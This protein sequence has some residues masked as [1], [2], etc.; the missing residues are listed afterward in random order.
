[1][2]IQIFKNVKREGKNDPDYTGKISDETGK[3]LHLVS[4]WE[5]N[6]KAG[7]KYLNGYVNEPRQT[8][9]ENNGN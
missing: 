5:N 6:S 1:M 9:T 2:K 4:L 7:T 8:T 3:V